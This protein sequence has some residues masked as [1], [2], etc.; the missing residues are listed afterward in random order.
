[1]GVLIALLYDHGWTILAI[2]IDRRMTY[3]K[4]AGFPR[5][6]VN[7]DHLKV[8]DTA[9]FIAKMEILVHWFW[10][11][12]LQGQHDISYITGVLISSICSHTPYIIE[13]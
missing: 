13:R 9:L 11:K 3:S 2:R 6:I 10:Q 5:Y 1:M 12:Q 8:N 4:T 7:A